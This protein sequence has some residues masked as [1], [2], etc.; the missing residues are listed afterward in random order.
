MTLS[1]SK[2]YQSL[3]DYSKVNNLITEIICNQTGICP[4]C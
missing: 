2:Q 1:E 3:S 4:L